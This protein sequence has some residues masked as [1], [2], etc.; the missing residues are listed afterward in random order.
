MSLA[1][2][3]AV[4]RRVPFFEKLGD[5]QL[6]LLAFGGEN[7]RFNS[8]DTLFGAGEETEGGLVIL[9]GQVLLTTPKGDDDGE[10]LKVGSLI[11]KRAL[12]APTKRR[13]T[14]TAVSSVEIMTIRRTLFLRMLREYPDT[15]S[16]LYAEMSQELHNLTTKAVLVVS[17]VP[18]R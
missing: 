17:D 12:L 5:D 18:S 2:D 11:G 4:L 14:A 8:G 7:T 13:N 1:S 15:A 9:S 10:R 3:M 6:R 16:A